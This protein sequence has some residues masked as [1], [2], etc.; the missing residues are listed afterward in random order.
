MPMAELY[1]SIVEPPRMPVIS[2]QPVCL[3]KPILETVV[4]HSASLAM[5]RIAWP[6]S[7]FQTRVVAHMPSPWRLTLAGF[8]SGCAIP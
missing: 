8:L 7:P 5:F 6:S 2:W 4:P 1:F 3:V